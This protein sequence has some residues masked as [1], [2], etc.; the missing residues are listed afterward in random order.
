MQYK[1]RAGVQDPPSDG[2]RAAQ[3]CDQLQGGVYQPA[4]TEMSQ[5]IPELIECLLIQNLFLTLIVRIMFTV[6]DTKCPWSLWY[7]FGP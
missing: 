7:H 3:L 2:G 5:G 4:R 6:V 1:V